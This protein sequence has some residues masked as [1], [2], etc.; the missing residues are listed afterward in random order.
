[1]GLIKDIKLFLRVLKTYKETTT[2][3]FDP[4]ITIIRS[5]DKYDSILEK[6]RVYEKE[7]HTCPNCGL[8]SF[9]GHGD[10]F[11]AHKYWDD[12]MFKI[13]TKSCHCAKCGT[14]WKYNVNHEYIDAIYEAEDR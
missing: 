3:D 11:F 1:M 2:E 6:A 12:D 14:I 8:Y 9:K 13:R 7:V 4:G 5:A 10:E